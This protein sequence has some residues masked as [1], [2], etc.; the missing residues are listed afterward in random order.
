MSKTGICLSFIVAPLLVVVPSGRAQGILNRNLIQNGGAEDGSAGTS[1]TNIVA[2][3][4]WTRT[5]NATVLPYDLT[6]LVQLRDPAPKDH[7]FNYFS[8]SSG[9]CGC[10]FSVSEIMRRLVRDS[11]V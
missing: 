7:G 2:I 9:T 8:V 1:A 5:G 3:P 11:S 4:R 6:G 10:V